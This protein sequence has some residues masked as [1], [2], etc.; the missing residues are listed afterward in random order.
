MSYSILGLASF[1]PPQTDVRAGTMMEALQMLLG[2]D[3]Y[4]AKLLE[5]VTLVRSWRTS[6]QAFAVQEIHEA[7]GRWYCGLYQFD[8]PVHHELSEWQAAIAAAVAEHQVEL[9]KQPIL[10][11]PEEPRKRR[12]KHWWKDDYAGKHGPGTGF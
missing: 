3:R 2:A 10:P 7:P 9:A 12:S 4:A 6:G 5:N 1:G 8:G 11:K